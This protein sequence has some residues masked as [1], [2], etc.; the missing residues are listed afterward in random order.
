MTSW[1]L[2][3]I[4]PVP[5]TKSPFPTC[6]S[7]VQIGSMCLWPQ[8]EP[9]LLG[10]AFLSVGWQ[11]ETRATYQMTCLWCAEW[12]SQGQADPSGLRHLVF[13]SLLLCPLFPPGDKY[14]VSVAVAACPTYSR[15]SLPWA[16]LCLSQGIGSSFQCLPSPEEAVPEPLTAASDS[17][18]CWV[19]MATRPGL[20][21][22]V[23][24]ALC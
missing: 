19:H 23:A 4:Q 5:P 18:G 13:L 8:Q 14:R 16:Y 2:L 22:G 7:K 20:P 15:L 21:T 6:L 24:R 3:Q 1:C 17:L 11:V 10:L 9:E 12:T